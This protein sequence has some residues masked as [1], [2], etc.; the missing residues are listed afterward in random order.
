MIRIGLEGIMA[1][2]VI[3]DLKQ[4]EVRC[5]GLILL[6]QKNQIQISLNVEPPQQ[7]GIRLEVDREAVGLEDTDTENNSLK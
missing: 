7:V 3:T 5:M 1:D 6:I 4:A 2:V